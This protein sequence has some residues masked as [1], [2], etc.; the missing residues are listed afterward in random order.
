MTISEEQIKT[1]LLDVSLKIHEERTRRGLSMAQLAEQ[2]NVSVSHISK[3]EAG[4][5]EVGLNAL[6]KIATAL[7][8]EIVDFLPPVIEDEK[9]DKLTSNGRRFESIVEGAEPKTVEFIL[10]VT[11]C[12]ADMFE[13][14]KFSFRQQN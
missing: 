8:L 3:V 7:G 11:A 6:L 10:A 2:A 12:M 13:G 1:I 14:K 5:C 4:K 9:A